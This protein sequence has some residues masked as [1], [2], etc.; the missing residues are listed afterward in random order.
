VRTINAVLNKATARGPLI[1]N[2][3]APA[4]G[5]PILRNAKE[6]SLADSSKGKLGDYLKKGN[7]GFIRDH[8]R[9]LRDIG[10]DERGRVDQE[11]YPTNEGGQ[12]WVGGRIKVQLFVKDGR[13][14]LA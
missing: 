9:K 2:S 5:I 14:S 10:Q 13:V 1:S 12:G 3:V 6:R 8:T 4:K 7:G 11:E